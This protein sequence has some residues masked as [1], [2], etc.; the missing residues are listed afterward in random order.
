MCTDC[1]TSPADLIDHAHSMLCLLN[2]MITATAINR[3]LT[4]SARDQDGLCYILSHIEDH[5]EAAL[6]KL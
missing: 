3:G 4:L 2:T 5:L 1:D 6:T